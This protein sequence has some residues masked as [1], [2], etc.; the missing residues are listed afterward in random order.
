MR[1]MCLTIVSLFL[2]TSCQADTDTP[3]NQLISY[4]QSIEK[5]D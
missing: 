1:I 4:D 2:L 3:F 5:D